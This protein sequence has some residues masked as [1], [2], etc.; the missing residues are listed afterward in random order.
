[1]G[2][3]LSAKIFIL[4][5]L[6]KTGKVN[7]FNFF[8]GPKDRWLELIVKHVNIDFLVA[9]V[10]HIVREERVK[11]WALLKELHAVLIRIAFV[12]VI[13]Q[14]VPYVIRV[15]ILKRSRLFNQIVLVKIELSI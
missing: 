1:M 3:R 11:K 9:S 6:L 15:P 14:L 7:A 5:G 4:L 12:V 2:S 13:H 8:L 10:G